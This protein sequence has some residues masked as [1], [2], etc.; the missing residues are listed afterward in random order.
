MISF[1]G[2][3]GIRGDGR[4]KKA[5]IP[6]RIFM[7]CEHVASQNQCCRWVLTVILFS[8]S[9]RMEVVMKGYLWQCFQILYKPSPLLLL[10]A[11]I[12]A[13]LVLS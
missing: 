3:K 8:D 11:A 12:A 13:V 2:L 4:E 10:G 1:L 9:Y 6:L 5:E 7:Q